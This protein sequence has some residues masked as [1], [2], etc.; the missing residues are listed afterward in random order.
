[1]KLNYNYFMRYEQTLSEAEP[2]TTKVLSISEMALRV[3]NID[4]EDPRRSDRQYIGEVGN[5]SYR[6]DIL[7]ME[8]LPGEGLLISGQKLRN[9][10]C[11]LSDTDMIELSAGRGCIKVSD[12]F[13]LSKD[14]WQQINAR[15]GDEEHDL[16]GDKFNVLVSFIER[17]F[18]DVANKITYI[19]Q[20]IGLDVRSTFDLYSRAAQKLEKHYTYSELVHSCFQE[21]KEMSEY[22]NLGAAKDIKN[23]D[24]DLIEKWFTG[25]NQDNLNGD[26]RNKGIVSF[27][28]LYCA[29]KKVD[30][31][32]TDAVES[33]LE[34]FHYYLEL[35]DEFKKNP[36]SRF[37][38]SLLVV[39]SKDT[40][41][42]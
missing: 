28:E 6:N 31:T 37:S 41:K 4:P 19:A 11:V 23:E 42:S 21:L 26:L 15:V 2:K 13:Q 7:Q 8:Y 20:T 25:C 5:P 12:F 3:D 30:M 27:F 1:M 22:S 39:L 17:E 16:N 38:D 36:D 18:D 24:I 35:T 9:D 40:S 29:L 10:S 33:A 34:N 32:D 14:E